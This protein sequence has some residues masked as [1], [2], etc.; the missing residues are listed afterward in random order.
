MT[1][2]QNRLLCGSVPAE[3]NMFGFNYSWMLLSILGTGPPSC[4]VLGLISI[5]LCWD[6][7]SIETSDK[8]MGRGG[9]KCFYSEKET[10]AVNGT[11]YMK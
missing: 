6:N 10:S 2:S 1:I 9:G 7:S 11:P 5:I 4:N 3:V 8:A